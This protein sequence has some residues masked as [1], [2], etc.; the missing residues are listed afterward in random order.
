MTMMMMMSIM[1]DDDDTYDGAVVS[2]AAV[3]A[4][5]DVLDVVTAAFLAFDVYNFADSVANDVAAFVVAMCVCVCVCVYC[6]SCSFVVDVCMCAS[7]CVFAYVR[8]L[9]ARARVRT[10]TPW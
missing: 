1:N 4:L 10:K 6:V 5:V 8:C 3:D 2:T 7:A 9:S